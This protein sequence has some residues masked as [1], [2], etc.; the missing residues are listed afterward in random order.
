MVTPLKDER[1]TV[2]GPESVELSHSIRCVSTPLAQC[3]PPYKLSSAHD[4][5][6]I[7]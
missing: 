4:I 3:A 6:G 5:M 1:A 7:S 2:E